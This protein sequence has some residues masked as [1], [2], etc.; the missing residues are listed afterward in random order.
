MTVTLFRRCAWVLAC[1]MAAC[2]SPPP[3]PK[4]TKP[5]GLEADPAHVAL[6]CVT[7]G[8]DTTHAVRFHVVGPRRVAIKRMFLSGAAP[9]EFTLTSTEETPFIV[10]SNASFEVQVRYAPVGSPLPA[11][12]ELRVTYTDASPEESEERLPA[13]EL[14]VPL[15]RRLV[16]EPVLAVAPQ[17][18]SFGYVPAGETKTRTLKATNE[19]FGN[20]ALELASIEAGSPLFTATLPDRPAVVGAEGLEFPTTFTPEADTYVQSTLSVVATASDVPPVTVKVEGTSIPDPRLGISPSGEV[21]FGE[22]ALKKSRT[23][24]LQLVNEGGAALT[25]RG[26]STSDANGNLS[27]ALPDA[28]APLHVASLERVPLT[29]TL[30]GG[31]AGE[32]DATVTVETDDPLQPTRDVRVRGTI[33]EPKLALSPDPLDFG[34]LPVGWVVKQPVELRNVGFG[35]L[36]VKDIRL[37]AGSSNLFV[38][39]NLPTLPLVLERDQRIAL[40]VQ[41]TAE[42]ASSFTGWLSV[43]TDAP[44]ATFSELPLKAIAGS[45]SSSCPIANGT[46][47]CS[48]GTCDV[49][50]CDTGWFNTDAKAAN[51]CECKEVGTDPGAFCADSHFAGTLMDS[52]KDQATFSG[53][54]PSEGDVD[55]VRFFGADG[56]T[57]L[58]ETYNVKVRLDSTDP[59]IRLCV[60]RYETG[61]HGQ[62]CYWT[63]EV[64]PATRTF[65]KGGSG[66]S[67]DDADYIV[68]VFR[69]PGTAPTCSSYTLFMSNGL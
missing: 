8:C 66:V 14:V 33:T 36:T 57:V 12:V 25:V 55:V 7:P 16:G 46:P 13:G 3:E 4:S 15:V 65:Q 68:K 29:L 19:G 2:A 62:D 49:G 59:N 28:G 38:L 30:Q 24:T 31:T 9:E 69:A 10:G 6:L 44:G 18:V 58:N 61:S 1:T 42:T 60:Y 40:D 23:V 47:S 20:I 17:T 22:V 48:S 26:V 41:F 64:C 5:P 45:C 53:V 54:L 67:G 11:P 50:S 34:T 39:S 35:P 43:E 27:V 63:N 37:V 56:F 21:D 52:K 51:G 32:L